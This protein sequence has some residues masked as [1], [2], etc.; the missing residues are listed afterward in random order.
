[1]LKPVAETSEEDFVFVAMDRRDL[2]LLEGA[3]KRFPLSHRMGEG[4]GEG[5]TRENRSAL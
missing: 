2:D 1:V 3:G 5:K 4:R